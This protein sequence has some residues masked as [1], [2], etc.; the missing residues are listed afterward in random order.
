[1]KFSKAV[2][3][4]VEAKKNFTLRAFPAREA[5]AILKLAAGSLF[6]VLHDNWEK[7]VASHI[8]LRETAVIIISI[9]F[10]HLE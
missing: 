4:D 5:F 1:V 7:I 9:S 2:S 8:N 3:V 10:S 6:W